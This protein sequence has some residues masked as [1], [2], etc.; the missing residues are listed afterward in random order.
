MLRSEDVFDLSLELLADKPHGSPQVREVNLTFA[1]L[2]IVGD[3]LE[4][5]GP[6]LV[7]KKEIRRQTL[8]VFGSN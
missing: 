7:G 2:N 5:N 4:Y 3:T 1:V 6:Y 8:S